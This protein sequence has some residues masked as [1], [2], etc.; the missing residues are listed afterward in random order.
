MDRGLLGR[1]WLW[2]RSCVCVHVRR[3][4]SP[5][6][7]FYASAKYEPVEKAVVWRIRS[8][9]GGEECSL[10]GDVELIMSTKQ[11]AWSRPPISIDFQVIK[12]VGGGGKTAALLPGW[13]LHAGCL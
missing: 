7:P 5:L 8:F 1:S 9:P 4:L 6:P 11:K 2:L 3:A 12:C 10:G 13:P